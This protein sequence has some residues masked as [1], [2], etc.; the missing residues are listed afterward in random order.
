MPFALTRAGVKRVCRQPLA[1]FG[2]D[3]RMNRKSLFAATTCLL[4]AACAAAPPRSAD[5]AQLD[6]SDAMI[7]VHD[8]LEIQRIA[9]STYVVRH[10]LPTPAN[11]VLARMAD[12]T[13]VLVSTPFDTTASRWLLEWIR[14]TFSPTRVVVI[15]THFH[16]DGSGGNAAFNAGGAETYGSSETA[17]LVLERGPAARASMWEDWPLPQ[18]RERFE[19]MPIEAPTHTFDPTAGITLSF[20][21]EDV[22]VRFPGAAHSPDNVVTYFPSRHLLAGGCMIKTG[23]SIGNLRDANLSSWPSAIEYIRTHFPDLQTVV[24]GHGAVGG[25]ELLDNTE[26]LATEAQ[27]THP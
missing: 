10:L 26:R 13:V 22:V 27:L 3:H 5:L 17:R 4:V 14:A 6:S 15:N 7:R 8:E 24:P 16:F 9:P 1:G 20:G 18:M 12:G 2:N 21:G 11:S 23:D 19:N 25:R